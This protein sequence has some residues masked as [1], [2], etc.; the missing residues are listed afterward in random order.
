MPRSHRSPAAKVLDFFTTTDLPSADLVLSLAQDTLR[1]RHQRSLEA[2]ARATTRHA[3]PT[4]AFSAAP[5]VTR[6][7]K[8]KA[9]KV[10]HKRKARATPPP[11]VEFD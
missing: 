2:K 5:P 8:R 9:T 11:A 6:V 4:P 7:Q 1:A 3:S 10:A